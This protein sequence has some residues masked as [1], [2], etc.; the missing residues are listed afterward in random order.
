MRSLSSADLPCVLG[1]ADCIRD[2]ACSREQCEVAKNPQGGYE[3]RSRGINPTLLIKADAGRVLLYG[4]RCPPDKVSPRSAPGGALYRLTRLRQVPRHATSNHQLSHGDKIG[5][6]GPAD[7]PMLSGHTAACAGSAS[8]EF[9]LFS[10]SQ[11]VENAH[12]GE[13]EPKRQRTSSTVAASNPSAAVG[14]NDSEDKSNSALLLG[15]QI[16][17]GTE[18]TVPPYGLGTL[19]LGVI[20]CRLHA[21]GWSLRR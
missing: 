19:P 5:L 8:T 7:P 13:R 20:Y 9:A 14:M 11:Q 3:V 16:K 17:L 10:D 12:L 15:P 1:R 18:T 6:L 21:V 4:K 2:T